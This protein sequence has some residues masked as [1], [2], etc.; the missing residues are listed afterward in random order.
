MISQALKDKIS[1]YYAERVQWMRDNN[2]VNLTT[3]T[4]KLCFTNHKGYVGQCHYSKREIRISEKHNQY[5]TWESIKDTINH[6]LAHWA[7]PGHGH[8]T[9]W[10]QMAVRLG[11]TPAKTCTLGQLQ[12]PYVIYCGA[13]IVGYSDILRTG[14]DAAG[15]Y[16]K[17]RKKQTFGR[18]VYK[19][20]PNFIDNSD[21][22]EP[23]V[24]KKKPVKKPNKIIT[25]F[26]S[27][28]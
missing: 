11:A 18:L 24:D 17:G 12:K 22:S 10:Q 25:D 6:E 1:L 5:A 19:P 28:L 20:N 9:V 7:T 8:D 2:I 13:E 4:Y 3:P 16:I 15:R 26:L 27:D 14:A 23:D 21:W